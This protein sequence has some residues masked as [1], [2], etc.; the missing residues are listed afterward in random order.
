MDC[1]TARMLAELRGSRDT[2]LPPEDNAS[3][4]DHVRTCRE[5]RSYIQ[6]ERQLDAHVGSAIRVV[7]IPADLKM[8]IRDRLA[9]E[10]GTWYRRRIFAGAAAAAVLFAAGIFIW[11]SSPKARLDLPELVQNADQFISNQK[12]SVD[13]WLAAKGIRYELP[14]PLDPRLTVAYGIAPIPI[15][16]G[17][18][19]QVPMVLLHNRE[20]NVFAHVFILRDDDFDLSS[21]Q[22]YDDPATSYKKK[23]KVIKG[24]KVAYIILYDGDSLD[25]FKIK[26]GSA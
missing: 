3:L 18:V 16:G 1:N 9:T 13:F 24:A 22:E 7:A 8:R 17:Q 21:I 2:E 11:G 12:G 14:E 26:V 10:R 19:K 4:D 6:F 5:C 15:Q 25:P 23:V 20:G